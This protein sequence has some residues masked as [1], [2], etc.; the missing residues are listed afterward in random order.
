M[1]LYKYSFLQNF[2]KCLSL[3]KYL[4]VKE[5]M[6]ETLTL[7]MISLAFGTVSLSNLLYL[8][9][10]LIKFIWF[11]LVWV[12]VQTSCLSLIWKLLYY[13]LFIEEY[14]ILPCIQFFKSFL[15]AQLFDIPYWC[16]FFNPLIFPL[17]VFR[18]AKTSCPLLQTAVGFSLHWRVLCR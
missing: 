1:R 16:R 8:T 4:G 17:V 2:L 11:L 10:V 6:E 5:W 7:I 18:G 9:T 15:N 12:G 14:L 3:T 13:S